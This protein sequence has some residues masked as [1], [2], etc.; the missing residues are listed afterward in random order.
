MRTHRKQSGMG[1]IELMGALGIGAMLLVGLTRM[2]NSSLD[3]LQSQQAAYYQS[4]VVHAAG[5]YIKANHDKI[6]TDTALPGKVIAVSL[7]QLRTG[8]FLPT[9]FAEQN[10]YKQNT[11]VLIRQPNPAAAPGQFDALVVTSGGEAIGDKDLAAAS[12][13]AGVGSG[14]IAAREPAVARGASWSIPTDPFRNIACTGSSVVLLRGAAQDAGHLVSNLF[15]D[16][17]GQLTADFLYRDKITD[18][19]DLN[20][21]TA[22]LRLGGSALV[23][24][25]ES[26]RDDLNETKPALALDQQTRKLLSCDANGFWRSAFASSWRE[27]VDAWGSLPSAGNEVGDVRMVTSLSR[28]FTFNGSTWVALA[29]DQNGNL[30]VPGTVTARDLHA[31][32]HIESDRGIHA[33]DHIKSDKNL[34]A[35]NDVL[36][37]RDIKAKRNLVTEKDLEVKGSANVGYELTALGVEVKGWMSTPQISIF[38]TFRPGDKCH[39]QVWSQHDQ[40]YVIAYPNGTVVMDAAYRPLICGLDRVFHYANG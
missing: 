8:N 26:C 25:N 34:M 40:K 38:D 30:D 29:V 6:K 2:A 24:I 16:G 11:C 20:R 18:R 23:N 33:A 19:P 13:H 9:G 39:Y 5:R 21:M 14:Y 12:M 10:A 36:A 35:G 4:Q 3:D 1:L 28:A 32:N 27:P 7:A 31:T 17:A 15:Y 37:D 22:P